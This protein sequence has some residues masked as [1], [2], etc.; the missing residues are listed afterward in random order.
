[1]QD[2]ER[3]QCNGLMKRHLQEKKEKGKENRNE[4]QTRVTDSAKTE[5]KA[6]ARK[7]TTTTRIVNIKGDTKTTVTTTKSIE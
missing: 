4:T 5:A 2:K 6:T 7:V 1:M 3:K